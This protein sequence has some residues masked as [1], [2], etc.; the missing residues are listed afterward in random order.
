[1]KICL[2]YIQGRNLRYFIYGGT[3]IGWL[4]HHHKFIPV[5]FI[6][7]FFPFFVIDNEQF[8]AVG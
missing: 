3:L 1:M 8:I 5:I 2:N 4:R 6:K 7:H